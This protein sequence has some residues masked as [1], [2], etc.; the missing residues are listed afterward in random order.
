M[1]LHL[2]FDVNDYAEAHYFEACFD[3]II[4]KYE[5]NVEID[6]RQRW[7]KARKGGG[8][9]GT[10]RSFSAAA[11]RRFNQ[12]FRRFG[13]KFQHFV[14]VTFPPEVVLY[15][16][17]DWQRL[18]R[19][20]WVYMARQCAR[21]NISYLWVREPHKSGRPHYHVVCTHGDWF[22]LLANRFVRRYTT[23]ARARDNL[24]V[25]LHKR[26][27]YFRAGAARYM[28]KLA[29]YCSKLSFEHPEEF[30]RHWGRNFKDDLK[31][32]YD[33]TAKACDWLRKQYEKLFPFKLPLRLTVA[34][35]YA[36][37]GPELN[38]VGYRSC[39]EQFL[40]RTR[41]AEGPL[42]VGWAEF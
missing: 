10:V 33:A 8:K 35:R 40:R 17:S 3:P 41:L 4:Y 20:F 34:D 27:I 9:R 24:H 36:E 18:C 6:F 39:V 22:R 29:R 31:G 1:W 42:N 30:Y 32:I 19:K 38:P 37:Y 23:A 26:T 16:G 28:A 14:T 5:N 13:G 7:P 15:E 2:A 11:K 21:R 12:A 25:G